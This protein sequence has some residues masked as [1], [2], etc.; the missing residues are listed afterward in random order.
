MR[1]RCPPCITVCPSG[2]NDDDDDY[3]DY[4]DDQDRGLLVPGRGEYFAKILCEPSN[5]YS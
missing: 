5:I 1:L 4:L 3:D 2:N